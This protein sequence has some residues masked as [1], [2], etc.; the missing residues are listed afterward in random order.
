MVPKKCFEGH[1]DI[2]QY[3]FGK[4]VHELRQANGLTIEKLAQ[5]VGVSRGYIS[6]IETSTRFF[7]SDKIVTK[8]ARALGADLET[9]LR[10]AHIDR[11]PLDIKQELL[12]SSILSSP[13]SV[14]KVG[15]SLRSLLWE[16]SPRKRKGKPPTMAPSDSIP[17]LSFPDGDFPIAFEKEED[18]WKT[19]EYMQFQ[20]AG[21][22]VSFALRMPDK[23]M[24]KARKAFFDKGNLVFFTP[25]TKWQ[26]Q[27]FVFVLYEAGSKGIQATFRLLE[28]CDRRELLLVAPGH[29]N[30]SET[31]SR[32]NVVG[33]WKAMGAFGSI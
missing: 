10:I 5:K 9:M 24:E 2:M 30:L 18:F 27:D 20:L 26:P 13:S 31:I 3:L 16:A 25:L 22:Q 21:S 32:K 15:G 8:L 14:D 7:P 6:H 4:K 28:D 17:I 11:I 1:R 33:T 12:Y 19:Q 29:R 23:S